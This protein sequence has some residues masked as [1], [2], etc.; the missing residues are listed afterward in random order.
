M[1]TRKGHVRTVSFSRIFRV[2]WLLEE[3]G[4]KRG[5]GVNKKRRQVSLTPTIQRDF[6]VIGRDEEAGNHMLCGKIMKILCIS[7]SHMIYL[8]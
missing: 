5:K 3:R 7:L 6:G 1:N 4:I 2:Q 8:L